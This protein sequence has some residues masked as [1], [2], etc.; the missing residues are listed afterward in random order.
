[1]IM[2]RMSGAESKVEEMRRRQTNMLR[3]RQQKK[4]V[5][6]DR[7]QREA[8]ALCLEATALQQLW[9]SLNPLKTT[10]AI[11]VQL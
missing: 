10:V 3:D 9:A 5:Q 7:E 4:K 2:E 8:D 6:Q 11:W 1:M